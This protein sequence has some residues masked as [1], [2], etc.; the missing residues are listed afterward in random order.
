MVLFSFGLPSRFAEWCDTI[1]ARIIEVAL[2]AV[3]VI[4]ADTLEE[5]AVTLLKV[6]GGNLFVSGRQPGAWLDRVLTTTEKPFIVSLGDPRSIV[7]ELVSRHGLDLPDATRRVSASCAAIMSCLRRPHALVLNAG[8]DWQQPAATIE[9]IAR[10]F[11]LAVHSCDIAKI[12]DDT[13]IFGDVPDFPSLV[14]ALSTDQLNDR[15]RVVVDEAVGP[16]LKHFLG[17]P[18]AHITWARELFLADG[19]RPAIQPVDVTGRVR[20]LIY[21]PYIRLPHGNWSAEVVLGFSQTATDV[22]FV[23]DVLSAGSQLCVTSFRPP[24]EGVYS[25]NLGFVINERSDHPVEFR[26]VNERAAFDGKVALSHV[27]LSRQQNLSVSTID[28]VKCEL[29]LTE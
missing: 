10:H 2:G 29:G 24:R 15:D 22:T 4:S 21:G 27:R 9:R 20:A 28:I 13:T 1:T 19:H 12:V 18:S 17:E 14:G 26:V 7:W 11:G 16:Y 23:V 25:I 3:T 6:E 5:L 8:P